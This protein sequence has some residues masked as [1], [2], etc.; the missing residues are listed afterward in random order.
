MGGA[1]LLLAGLTGVLTLLG[2]STYFKALSLIGWRNKRLASALLAY[3]LVTPFRYRPN[4]YFTKNMNLS[5]TSA[6]LALG[7]L[8]LLTTPAFAQAP[9]H[10]TPTTFHLAAGSLEQ[11]LTALSAQAGCSVHY[12]KTLV[13]SFRVPAVQGQLTAAD[14][15]VRLVHGTGLEAHS[16]AQGLSVS[17]ADQE[18]IGLRAATLQAQVGQALKSQTLAQPLA[19]ALYA[20]LGEV[21]TSVTAVARQQGFVSAAEKASYQ[22]TFAKAEQ[23]LATRN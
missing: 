9:C 5:V 16:D 23:V 15:L 11:A 14:A 6:T 10:P 7:A 12:D 21:R 20:E 4:P 19:N 1:A 18:T 8:A 17:Q 2:G 13:R 22:R 3:S